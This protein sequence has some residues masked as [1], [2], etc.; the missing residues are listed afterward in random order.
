MMLDLR[1]IARALGGEV[2]GRQ[3]LAPGP[4]HSPRD[5]SLAVQLSPT[6]PDGFVVT[7][8]ADDDGRPCRDHVRV[9]LGIA[10]NIFPLKQKERNPATPPAENNGKRARQIWA[11]AIDPRGT[12]AETY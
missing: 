3:G 6:A 1:T 10:P 12:L 4:G 7:S 9:R 8:F 5:R 11:E 2:S